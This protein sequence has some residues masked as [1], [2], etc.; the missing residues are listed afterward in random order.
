MTPQKLLLQWW[1]QTS[2]FPSQQFSFQT[3]PHRTSLHC[4]TCLTDHHFYLFTYLFLQRPLFT[5]MISLLPFIFLFLFP[6][7]S[8]PLDFICG[9]FLFH[10]LSLGSRPP[11]LSRVSTTLTRI[12]DWGV[13][14]GSSFFKLH[15]GLFHIPI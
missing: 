6:T 10:K 13:K 9:Y 3:S 14:M 11:K 12:W 8:K 1:S 7:C 4:N 5:S 2:Y 15:M